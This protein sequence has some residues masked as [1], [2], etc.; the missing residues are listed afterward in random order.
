MIFL[1]LGAE[2]RK[3]ISLLNFVEPFWLSEYLKS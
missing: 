2:N 1:K 3:D